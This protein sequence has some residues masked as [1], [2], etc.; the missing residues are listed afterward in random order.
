MERPMRLKQKRT[1][2]SG[3]MNRSY[4]PPEVLLEENHYNETSDMWSL[5]CLLAEM[6]KCTQ[7]ESEALDSYIFMKDTISE[8]SSPLFETE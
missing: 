8:P 1:M 4:A 5:G 2:S 3:A 7:N 6:L